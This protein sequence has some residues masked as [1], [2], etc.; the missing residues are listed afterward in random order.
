MCASLYMCQHPTAVSMYPC[1]LCQPFGILG[2]FFL[3]MEA[4]ASHWSYSCGRA[5]FPAD[6]LLDIHCFFPIFILFF[7]PVFQSLP[8]SRCSPW[9]GLCCHLA[10][11]SR[12]AE[13]EH[14]AS[15][16]KCFSAASWGCATFRKPSSTNRY[17][18][19]KKEN[20]RRREAQR[21]FWHLLESCSCLPGKGFYWMLCGFY[22][23]LLLGNAVG[24]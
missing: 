10:S 6:S 18:P 7:P 4:G 13:K 12:Q 14:P 23:K 17:L 11:L 3:G 5:A 15:W 1:P 21:H 8:S 16:E 9:L 22:S 24:I 2:C 20:D 19:Q